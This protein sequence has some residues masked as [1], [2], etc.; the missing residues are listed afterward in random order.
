MFIIFIPRYWINTRS[1]YLH[2]NSLA[3]CFPVKQLK[4][5]NSNRH[6]KRCHEN[7]FT[8]HFICI[9]FFF[10]CLPHIIN[11]F[12][13]I[14]EIPFKISS[15][16]NL[17]QKEMENKNISFFPTYSMFQLNC[18]RIYVFKYWI[19]TYSQRKNNKRTY[20]IWYR[21]T[22]FIII[23][24]N[25]FLLRS[26]RPYPPHRLTNRYSE[27]QQNWMHRCDAFNNWN[28]NNSVFNW[29]VAV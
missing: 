28:A 23:L 26:L 25:W 18:G 13:G 19:I 1:N 2:Q 27:C 4:I 7:I 17:L 21:M 12:I 8:P 24:V 9:F 5:N 15:Y 29:I 6:T 11:Y 22:Y 3:K 14:F 10:K 16:F 20:N